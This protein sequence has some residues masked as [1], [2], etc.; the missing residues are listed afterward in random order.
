MTSIGTP[1]D[2]NRRA[3]SNAFSIRPSFPRFLLRRFKDVFP[4]PQG[5]EALLVGLV[6]RLVE[7]GDLG[8]VEELREHAVLEELLLAALHLH[9]ELLTVLVLAVHVEHGAPVG[10]ARAQVL[11][12][13]VSQLLDLLTTVKQAVDEASQKVLVHLRPEQLLEAE[14]G[15]RV[16]VAVFD[17]SGDHGYVVYILLC[18]IQ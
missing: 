4:V 15:V 7:L 17:V 9:Q 1:A 6:F 13:Q 5:F 16:D 10:L 11:G 18:L 8:G 12:V 2:F 14:V 3:I